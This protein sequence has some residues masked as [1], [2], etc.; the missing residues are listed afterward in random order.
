[1]AI[2]TED[3]IVEYFPDLH[4]YGIQDFNDFIA[5][6]EADIHRLLRIQWFPK[7]SS[8]YPSRAGL[9][10]YDTTRVNE[11]QLTRSGVYYCLYKYILPQLTQWA[12][13]GDSFQT[14]IDFYRSAFD[15]EFDLATRELIYDWDSDGSYEESERELQPTQRLVR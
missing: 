15:E 7:V 3:N 12:V 4:N 2:F 14:Q 9:G 13:E 1:M 8:N 11:S 10:H 5:K 6:T